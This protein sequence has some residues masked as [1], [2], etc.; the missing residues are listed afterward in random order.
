MSIR[1]LCWWNQPFMCT[2]MS[3]FTFLLFPFSIK[4]QMR[5]IMFVSVFWLSLESKLRSV[6]Q[7]RILWKLDNKKMLSMQKS[8]CNLFSLLVV[9][10]MPDRI[11]FV[12]VL[13]CYFM[14]K[15]SYP[16][17]LSRNFNKMF[18]KMSSPLLWTSINKKV[19]IRVS[20]L[21]LPEIVN[22]LVHNLSW[23]LSKLW[24]FGMHKMLFWIH[25]CEQH[26]NM[27]STL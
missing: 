15:L 1:T 20:N 24:F 12:W 19:P 17:L 27:Q 2:E 16:L 13:M 22:T 7:T 10:N 23:W 21:I 3:H 6:M 11:L 8:V 9:P 14:S 5:Q 26:K 25:L 18:Q 4:E